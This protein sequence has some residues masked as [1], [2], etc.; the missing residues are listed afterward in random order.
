M[1]ILWIVLPGILVGY[2]VFDGV[3]RIFSDDSRL[4]RGLFEAQPITMTAAAATVGSI[5]VW[6]ALVLIGVW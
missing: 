4:V 5:L 1:S 3:R 6:G 2:L